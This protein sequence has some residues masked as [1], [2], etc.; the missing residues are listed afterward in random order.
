[1]VIVTLTH[2]ASTP[3]LACN[4]GDDPTERAKKCLPDFRG[5]LTRKTSRVRVLPATRHGNGHGWVASHPTLL[6]QTSAG[7]VMRGFSF[8]F[9]VNHILLQEQ[10]KHHH[11]EERGNVETKA[12]D[13]CL[14]GLVGHPRV[15]MSTG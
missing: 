8:L 11:S 1:M 5:G 6:W 7:M 14:L 15:I 10:G 2:T 4:S 3:E 12:A 9:S 13:V